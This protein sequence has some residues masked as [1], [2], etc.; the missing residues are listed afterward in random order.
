VV[1]EL[2]IRIEELEARVAALEDAARAFAVV[3]AIPRLPDQPRTGPAPAGDED[4]KAIGDEGK[5]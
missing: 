5:H 3:Y 4:T 2:F 1:D